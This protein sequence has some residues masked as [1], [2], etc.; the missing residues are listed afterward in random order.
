MAGSSYS[1]DVMMAVADACPWPPRWQTEPM[2]GPK[3]PT[4]SDDALCCAPLL[5]APVDEQ[6]A[7]RLAAVMKSLADPAR[8]RLLSIIACSPD[9][10]ACACDLPALVDRSQPTVSHHLS[11]LVKV[12]ILSREQ[13]GKWA[14]FS[15]NAEQIDLLCNVLST[16]CCQPS[17]DAAAAS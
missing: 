11:Q 14:W 12:G 3:P 1:L 15:I 6:A 5:S 4:E 17:A 10:E 16:E 13:R 7:T 2:A 8:L 9:G